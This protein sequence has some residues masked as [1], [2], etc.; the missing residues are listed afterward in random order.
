MKQRILSYTLEGIL[1]LSL[2]A[3]GGSP[4]ST[5]S[6]PTSQVQ[7]ANTQAASTNTLAIT[8]TNAFTDSYGTY[9]VV[10]EVVNNTNAAIS[11]IELAI[12]I[13]DA[14]GN[15]LIKDDAGNVT[16]SAQVSPMLYTLGPGEASPF[17]Y[18]YETSKGTPASYNVTISSQ[19][20]GSVN[21]ASLNVENVQLVNDGKGWYYLTGEMLNTGNKWAHI[22]SLAGA[23]MDDASHVL[24]ADWTATYATELAPAGDAAG[25]DRTPFEINF[26]NP[27]GATKWHVYLD[28]DTTD[29][30][31]D[32]PL[33][34][35]ISNTY[36][37]QYGSFH[38]VG[39]LANNSSSLL[40][41]LVVAGVYGA[42]KTV[43]DSSYSFVPI[44]IK[45]GANGAF[46]VSSF[47]SINYNTN[48][49]SLVSTTSIQAD[50]WFT[51]PP[52]SEVVDLAA[53]GE[54][55]TKN[56]STWTFDGN[57][58]NTSDKSLSGATVEVTILDAQ[59][60]LIAMEYTSIS[61]SG[62][63]IA[64]GDSNTYSVTIYLDTKA[65]TG[66]FTTTTVVIGDVK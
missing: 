64:P 66:G 12:E 46:S 38:V 19:K 18:S 2:I 20:P 23:V 47:S 30:V 49:A 50:P 16:S 28:A 54:T 37:D 6:V 13:K 31:I 10:G 3:C 58:I 42:D 26:P 17:E 34:V 33:G 29:S 1:I 44:P 22:N 25:R 4:I 62:D 51:S 9:H 5:A 56:G 40:D 61:P 57:V 35:T 41:S 8:S 27:G 15:S 63:A 45:Q 60:K 32:Y 59:N 43:L 21:R 55:I 11:S 52:T 48:Q 36:F 65:N 53:S 39:W 7:A 14:T 24:S